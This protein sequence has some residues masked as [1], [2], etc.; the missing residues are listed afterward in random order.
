ML[1][2]QLFL[3][4]VTLNSTPFSLMGVA[5]AIFLSFRI[6]ASYDRFWEARKQWGSVLVEARNLTPV[7]YTHLDVYKRQLQD[8]PLFVHALWRNQRE[9]ALTQHLLFGVA[10][11]GLRTMVPAGDLSLIHI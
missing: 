3:W 1:H 5:L 11:D 4:K 7:S 10:K 6:N 9:Y 8:E 2:G